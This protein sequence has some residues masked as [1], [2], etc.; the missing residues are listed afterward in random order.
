M[1]RAGHAAV[2]SSH[3]WDHVAARMAPYIESAA[4]ATELPGSKPQ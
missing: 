1:G 4:A 2:T 3:T